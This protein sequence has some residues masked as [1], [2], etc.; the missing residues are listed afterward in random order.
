MNDDFNSPVAIAS[1]FEA[2]RIINSVKEGHSQIN[3]EELEQLKKLYRS[4][5]FDILGLVSEEAGNDYQLVDGLMQRL[6]SYAKM[7]H[8]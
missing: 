6:Y 8:T 1:L 2:V 7:P 4:F 3:A 5:V